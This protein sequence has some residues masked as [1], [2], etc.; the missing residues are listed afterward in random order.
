MRKQII[1]KILEILQQQAESTAG[2]IDVF[3]SGYG[4]SYRKSRKMM[5]EGAPQFKV[6]WAEKYVER[7]RFY[8]LLNKLKNEG[9]IKKDAGKRNNLWNITK[10]GI[11]KLKAKKEN[12]FN[13]SMS[14]YEVESDDKLKIIIFD[15]PEKERQKRKW[16]RMVLF[17][18]GFKLLQQSVWMGKGRVPKKFLIDLRKQGMLSYIHIFEINKR[19]TIE[20]EADYS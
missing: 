20:N 15:I 10:K 16:L 9:F 7:Q 3:L 12:N 18:L 4:E 11:E 17:G 19:G 2:L 14:E 6:D 5:V 8:S 1:P 13:N